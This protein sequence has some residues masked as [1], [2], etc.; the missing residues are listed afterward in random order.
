VKTIEW[1]RTANQF[2]PIL[3]VS[4]ERGVA[5]R[6]AEMMRGLGPVAEVIWAG[7]VAEAWRVLENDQ[8]KLIFLEQP[9]H[10]MDA[11]GLVRRLRLSDLPCRQAAVVM[12]S[13]EATVGAMR[14][15]QAAGAH[16]FL[17]R[18][19]SAV[20]LA[21]RLEAIAAISRDWIEGKAYAGPDRRR[22]NSA[23][24]GPERRG[25]PKARDPEA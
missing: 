22:F 11:L 5:Q 12:M 16:E 4:A 9:G 23:A 2:A 13:D 24:K 6:L 14:A 8:P 18:P 15:A 1:T 19:F 17:I 20:D 7:G 21:K 25:R 3:V 10:E